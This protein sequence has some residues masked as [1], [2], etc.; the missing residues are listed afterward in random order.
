[1]QRK[2][3]PISEQVLNE[4]STRWSLIAHPG[5]I[6]P[7][8]RPWA[9]YLMRSGRGGG[10]TRAGSEWVLQRVRDGYRNIAL[11]GQTAAD[12]RDTM[13]EL[14]ESSI[15]RC[16]RSKERPV[17]EPSKRRLTFPNGAIAIAYNGDQPDQLR[18]PQHDTCFVRGSMI[19]STAGQIPIQ[20]V[21]VG[22]TVITRAGLQPIIRTLARTAEVGRVMFSNGTVLRGTADHPVLTEKGW[23]CMG[24]LRAGEQCLSI[25][26]KHRPDISQGMRADGRS[27]NT[28]MYGKEP[29]G[30]S[31]PDIIST[32]EMGTPRITRL[33]IL[34]RSPQRPTGFATLK[35]PSPCKRDAPT[36]AAKLSGT[37]RT[38]GNQYVDRASINERNAIERSPR[39]A[40]NA[41]RP[42][43]PG[44]GLIAVSVASIWEPDGKDMVYNLTV[45]NQP[46]YFVNG[47]LVHNCWIDE[48]AKFRYPEACWDNLMFGLR[49]GPN[50][51][52]FVTT[53][54]RPTKIIKQL[55]AA[56]DTIDVVFSTYQNE[57]NLSPVFIQRIKERYEGTRL[58]R[59][60]LYGEILID[61]PN[62]LWTRDVIDEQRT[63]TTPTLIKIVVG[64][65]PAVTSKDT[66]DET[67]IVVAGI[68]ANGHC[69]VLGD[70]SLQGTPNAWAVAAVKAYNEHK[71]D[72]IIGE[73]NNGG[74]L[75][76]VNIRTVGPK[77][78]Y[79]AVH[80][81]RG[82]T[83]RAEPISAMYEQ[84]KVHHV[85]AFPQLEDQMCD[86]IPGARS[87]DRV[88]A[89][90]WAI[91]ELIPEAMRADPSRF[92]RSAVR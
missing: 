41:A 13:I 31:H 16:A 54:P 91:T 26:E 10:K 6:P 45:A 85:G 92:L 46:E 11:I 84:G 49:Q 80:A 7:R 36:V 90:V 76:E 79:R 71:A 86:W 82:K 22:D 30:A 19:L 50:P 29:T 57:K 66:S 39:Y 58:G 37:E 15:M 87:P 81:S 4:V 28:D 20:D 75:V 65:D 60:E 44:K 70:H 59:Q 72:R 61:N 89:L 23:V 62:A 32:T 8:D 63:T 33:G 83:A 48:L 27:T 34:K 21:S 73:V 47:I 12:V 74:D 51:Q 5:Q 78:P 68:A 77:V 43:S 69:Y 55:V 56:P 40:F 18:G 88:D 24:E 38:L 35:R 25:G 17:Y 3:S 53:T 1:M 52:V 2:L 14:G 9:V 67:G 64:V 42:L